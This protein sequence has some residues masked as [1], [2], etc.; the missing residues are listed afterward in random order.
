[1]SQCRDELTRPVVEA[2]DGLWGKSFDIS[3]LGGLVFCGVTGFGAA[4]AHAPQE[5]GTGKE[6]YVVFCGPHIA[7]GPD[8]AIG[9]VAR[10]GRVQLSGACGALQAFCGELERGE[11]RVGLDAD[12]PEQSLL[13]QALLPY[14]GLGV[15]G[16]GKGEGPIDLVKLTKCAEKRIHDDVV[17][18]LQVTASKGQKWEYAV[19]SGQLRLSLS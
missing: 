2:L 4:L 17:R 1:M 8:G 12:D 13:R 14:L 5:P 3:G 7:I 15:G 19:V 16:A 10:E 9:S 6:R 11:L 18:M